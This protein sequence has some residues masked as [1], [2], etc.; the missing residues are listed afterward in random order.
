MIFIIPFIVGAIGAAIGA[1][2][3]A[4]AARGAG[5]K[6]RQEAKHHRKVA[7]ELLNKYSELQNRYYELEEES[8]AVIL[9]LE[10]Q[11][12]LS[13]I[14]KDTLHLVTDL[15]QE[16][17][18]LMIAIDKEPSFKALENLKRAILFTNLALSKFDKQLILM[19]DD[20]IIRNLNR[21]LNSA[22]DDKDR[23][24]YFYL[25]GQML[26]DE[27]KYQDAIL[28]YDESINLDGL[29]HSVYLK[30]GKS[31]IDLGRY[32]ESILTLNVAL[33]IDTNDAE[34]WSERALAY[35]LLGN[36]IEESKSYQHA[37]CA[38]SNY[39]QVCY[40]NGL[41]YEEMKDKSQAIKY[42]NQAIKIKPDF[43]EAYYN[44]GVLFLDLGDPLSDVDY[45]TY[46]QQAIED[47]K[48]SKASKCL[49]YLTN[50]ILIFKL[51]LAMI[52]VL[53]IVIKL[54]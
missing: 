7:N 41:L 28:C 10:R 21:A 36:S 39:Y 52:I 53:N 46:R 34:I 47:L 29:N 37:L 18:Q 5:E 16:I 2:G 27:G 9:G 3:G 19:P 6:D 14:E 12:I 32:Q 8:K 40:E 13:E 1:V 45:E 23:A 44:R 17:I 48:I 42:Y 25:Y 20:Y 49:K 38:T 54:V 43:A 50:P 26:H 4:F 35:S 24:Y 30:K 31:L 22:T 15:Q 33:S 11:L 51:Y